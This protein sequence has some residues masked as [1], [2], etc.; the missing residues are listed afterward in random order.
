MTSDSSNARGAET[1]LRDDH[2]DQYRGTRVMVLGAS[3]FIGQSVA[4]QL[5]ARGAEVHLAVRDTSRARDIFRATDVHRTFVELDLLELDRLASQLKAIRPTVTFN[6]SGYGVD[7]SQRDERAAFHI[8]ATVV[9]TVAEV[10]A[11]TDRDAWPGQTLV[12][13]GSVL[14]YGTIGGDLS[15]VS[16]PN[17]T[18]LYGR[19]KLA[20]TLALSRCCLDHGLNAVTARLATV[21]GP[22]EHDGRLLPSLLDAATSGRVLPLTEGRQQRDFTYVQDVAEGILRLA[23]VGTPRGHIVNLVTGRLTTVRSFA[24]RAAQVLG[25]PRDR[26]N[27]G[28]LPRRPEEMN[29]EPITLARLKRLT[30][31]SPQTDVVS[32]IRATAMQCI[33]GFSESQR[34]RPEL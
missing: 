16:A 24:C 1:V 8:N 34:A 9:Q 7:P 5:L 17:P 29:H 6:L 27:F 15:E 21:Y 11:D 30:R 2:L 33:E 4:H 28:A 26:L 25:I 22:G 19:S 32:G 20:G 12:H 3:G 14:E 23:V 10:L 13:A 18:T 31:W